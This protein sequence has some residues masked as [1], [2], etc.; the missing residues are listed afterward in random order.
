[1]ERYFSQRIVVLNVLPERKPS[2]YQ[3]TT[4]QF[5]HENVLQSTTALHH[6]QPFIHIKPCET[7]CPQ[8]TNQSHPSSKSIH[9]LQPICHQDQTPF[10]SLH[11]HHSIVKGKCIK[12]KNKSREVNLQEDYRHEQIGATFYVRSEQQGTPYNARGRVLAVPDLNRN[13]EEPQK[14]R[15]EPVVPYQKGSL[16][17]ACKRRQ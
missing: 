12:V 1:M 11:N 14:D 3:F 9:K 17:Y 2:N 6:Y 10:H 13:E 7:H 8:E 4:I 5:L 15:Y 16:P